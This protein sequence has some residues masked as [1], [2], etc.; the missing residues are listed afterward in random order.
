MSRKFTRPFG[1]LALAAALLCA[2]A[3]AATPPARA[4]S[5][6]GEDG[7]VTNE[8]NVKLRGAADLQAVA[9]QHKLQLVEQFGSRPIYRM[10]VTDGTD[11]KVKASAVAA[12]TTRVE[13]AEAN[14]TAGSPEGS[15]LTW[16]VAD[17]WNSGL[18]WSVGDAGQSGE[19]AYRG[20][21]AVGKIRLGEAHRA[22]KGAGMI[23]AVLDTG[24]DRRHPALAGRLLRVRDFVDD[25][26]DPS[27]VL[28]T[29]PPG[30][31]S[32]DPRAC[33][34][35]GHGTHVAGLV[36]LAAPEAK[37]MPLRVLDPQ[38]VGNM[39]VI[40][41]ALRYALD[42]DGDPASDDGADVI[43]MSLATFNDS[44]VLRE[45]VGDACD[46]GVPSAYPKVVVVAAAGNHG[47]T[48]PMYPAAENFDGELSV[49]ASKPD[50]TLAEFS[51]RDNRVVNDVMSPGV[52]IT[53]SVPGAATGVWAGTSMSAPLVAGLAAL[54]R[55][56]S[57]ELTAD[58]VKD[59]IRG[60][61]D[62][63][64]PE[65]PVKRRVNAAAAVVPFVSFDSA[66]NPINDTR[67]FVRQQYLDFLSRAPDKSGADFWSGG[68]DGC[69]GDAGCT[70]LRRVSTSGAFFLSIEFRDT[71]YF[72]YRLHKAA[73][74]DLSG[75]PVPVRY[76]DFMPDTQRIGEGV[77]VNSPGW[78]QKLASNRDAFVLDFVKRA[79][80]A[81][82]FPDSLT[83]AE[84]V[85]RLF[86][87]AGVTPTDGERQ[88]AV[89]EFGGAAASADTAARARAL[90]RVADN[91]ALDRQERNR[92]FVLMQYFGY[93]RRNPDDADF[94][95]KTDPS[96][97]GYNF[98]LSKLEGA[99]GDFI[100]AE[101]VRAFIESIEYRRRFRQ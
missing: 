82:A 70:Q 95:G 63:P 43:N 71:G 37:I 40:A 81:S 62:R 48:T 35:Y 60:T 19:A 33:G 11:A 90:K 64:E 76:E 5:G 75:R 41:E 92:A 17:S 27:E 10:R 66:A 67:N 72:V 32:T 57:P 69:K 8:V 20:Q 98:W 50:D 99:G 45:V 61:S 96:F 88:G 30:T 86:A 59:R 31:T 25:D 65:Q 13:Y 9:E 49:A 44:R 100:R 89:N 53:S 16:S 84:F 42:P 68:L 3:P 47:T 58:M 18:T 97:S 14:W 93:L 87:N 12:D 85:N 91:D 51:Q 6:S 73:F 36:A 1:P 39:W 83:P 78:E 77:V 94:D 101:M 2:G 7:Y 52:Q 74:G 24:V 26:D 79:R 15:G 46:T 29:C 38:G 28:P 34:P 21:W 23:V 80:F 55:A 4:S 54:V 56:A 22:T